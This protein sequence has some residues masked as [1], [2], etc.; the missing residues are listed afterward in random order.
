MIH[1]AVDIYPPSNFDLVAEERN[2]FFENV[3]SFNPVNRGVHCLVFV[4]EHNISPRFQPSTLS[5]IARAQYFRAS[6]HRVYRPAR[7][8]P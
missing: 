4:N 2:V 7:G 8:I 1:A 5:P 6:E 3:F